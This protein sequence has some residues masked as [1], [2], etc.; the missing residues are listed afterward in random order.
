MEA[1]A[2]LLSFSTS[3]SPST[4]ATT[5]TKL[6]KPTS[7]TT[8][9][10]PPPLHIH[11]PKNK[12]ASPFKSREKQLLRQQNQPPTLATS[13]FSALRA[14]TTTSEQLLKTATCENKQKQKKRRLSQP[15]KHGNNKKK[16]KSVRPQVVPPRTVTP[17]PPSLI[18][19][20]PDL[21]A[22]LQHLFET[23][24]HQLWPLLEREGWCHVPASTVSAEVFAA[25]V[26]APGHCQNKFRSIFDA[27]M[28]LAAVPSMNSSI[29]FIV[30]SLLEQRQR[31]L[32]FVVA[33]SSRNI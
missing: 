29:N 26:A 18:N 20:L 30:R 22:R 21:K 10:Q 25:P 13:A 5:P 6:S 31:T 7:P 3:L 9:A 32:N 15:T 11:L 27:L 2:L 16:I 19:L 14:L 24:W 33:T 4:T 8:F 28:Y 12:A 1:A 17:L 23:F